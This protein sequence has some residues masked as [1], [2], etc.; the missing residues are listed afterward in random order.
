MRASRL[1]V[2]S[3][4]VLV[5]TI[6][7]GVLGFLVYIIAGRELSVSAYG[8][9]NVV[10]AV[11]AFSATLSSL[12][13]RDALPRELAY[14][15]AR[16]WR[17]EDIVRAA[18]LVVA[19]ASIAVGG[20]LAVFSNRLASF[21]GVMRY[22][23]SLVLAGLATPSM[24]LLDL[25]VAIARGYG[26]VMEK[27]L[28]RD[29][30]VYL[31]LLIGAVL[32]VF[33]GLGLIG[34]LFSYVIAWNLGAVVAALML[35]RAGLL[36]RPSRVKFDV[37]VSLLAF[38]LPLLV[39]GVAGIVMTYMDT[40]MLG[41][42]RGAREVG[43]YNAAAPLARIVLLVL[44]SAGYIVLPLFSE[45]YAREGAEGLRHVYTIIARWIF[46]ATYPLAA[47]MIAAPR[48]L[49]AA[50]FG[51]RYLAIAPALAVLAAGFT[52]HVV[53]GFNGI[54]VMVLRETRVVGMVSILSATVN[55]VLNVLLIPRLGSLGAAAATAASYMLS[56]ALI[57]LW[58]YK[59][60]R[61]NPFT[62][63]YLMPLSLAAVLASVLTVAHTLCVLIPLLV[64]VETVLG[65]AT[66]ATRDAYEET[67]IREI[68]KDL[69]LEW[70]AEKLLNIIPRL[71]WSQSLDD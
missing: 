31:V 68:A 58:L 13:L 33:A 10:M 16:G 50:V 32:S 61:L 70:L 56:N 2:A 66:L 3:A 44:G 40:L 8:V 47:A 7:S 59:R 9:F 38:S 49:V 54:T 30:G 53:A 67:L 36:P 1:L 5:G 20:L 51:R 21:L 23:W 69:G 45:I 52:A 24:V 18:L 71:Q 57:S 11:T 42:F 48:L 17:V 35:W 25:F 65:V 14:S 37:I 64:A 28:V 60:I 4:L 19:L 27:I 34:V 6:V 15:R 43:L 12:G 55:A 22:S 63:G 46:V 41:V 39:S 62:K 26:R 29:V